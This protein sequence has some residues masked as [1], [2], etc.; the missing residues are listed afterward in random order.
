MSGPISFHKGDFSKY[1][2]YSG[3]E[4]LLGIYKEFKDLLHFS[5]SGNFIPNFNKFQNNLKQLN[6]FLDNPLLLSMINGD[7]E[8]HSSESV[9]CS[10]AIIFN[11]MHLMT[12]YE[13][14]KVASG[15]L[16]KLQG[17]KSAFKQEDMTAS[18]VQKSMVEYRQECENNTTLVKKPK[19][20]LSQELEVQ[21]K[22]LEAILMIFIVASQSKTMIPFS[23]KGLEGAKQAPGVL[24]VIK[25]QE[26]VLEPKKTHLNPTNK[27]KGDSKSG[28]KQVQEFEKANMQIAEQQTDRANATRL[29][30]AK[31]EEKHRR[32]KKEG[33]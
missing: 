26:S 32:N 16:D 12:Q 13:D 9:A 29:S 4:K 7:V 19:T 2:D 22:E 27:G 5:Q 23:Q 8:I 3:E 30:D 33:I 20:A 11:T 31:A 21:L 17:K 15:F 6:N 25:M 28:S 14:Q 18:H 10:G 24:N 1:P